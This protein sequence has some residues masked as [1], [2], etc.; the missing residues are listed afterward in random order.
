MKL[1]AS[2]TNSERA[3]ANSKKS[4]RYCNLGEGCARLPRQQRFAQ[5]TLFKLRPQ[6]PPIPLRRRLPPMCSLPSILA[7]SRSFSPIRTSLHPVGRRLTLPMKARRS[8]EAC[9]IV[10]PKPNANEDGQGQST[11]NDGG[12]WLRGLLDAWIPLARMLLGRLAA[13][14]RP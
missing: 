13:V 1:L 11:V 9:L 14:E 3:S 10:R 7:R 12:T 2:A 5:H 8:A 4:F 6:R